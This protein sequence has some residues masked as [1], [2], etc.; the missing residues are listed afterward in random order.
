[1]A[2]GLCFLLI[3]KPKVNALRISPCSMEEKKEGPEEVMGI[4]RA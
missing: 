1:M 3:N 2:S 4:W